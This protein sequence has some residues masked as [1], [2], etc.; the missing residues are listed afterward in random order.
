MPGTRH[1]GTDAGGAQHWPPPAVRRGH[2][3]GPPL[4]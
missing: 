2:H 1:A 4:C 3:P